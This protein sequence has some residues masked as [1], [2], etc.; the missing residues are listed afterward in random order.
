MAKGDFGVV[1]GLGIVLNAFIGGTLVG[2][3]KAVGIVV[4]F[5]GVVG[6]PDKFAKN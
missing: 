2:V 1:V 3:L 5:A 6:R 4:L